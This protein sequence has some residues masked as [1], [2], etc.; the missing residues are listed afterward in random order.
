VAIHPTHEQEQALVRAFFGGEAA[1]YFVEVGAN[2]PTQGSQTW[3]LEQAGWTG[4]LVEPQPDLAAFLVSARKARVFAVACSSPDNAGKSMPLHVKGPHS[5]LD[6]E[7][8]SPGAEAA[9]A[10]VVPARTLD[11]ILDEAGAPSPIDLL[12]ID[13]EGHEVEV[14]QGFDFGRWQPLLILIE[15]HVAN[16]KT[17]RALK[18]NGYRLIRR[19]GHNGWYVPDGDEAAGSWGDRWE[20]LRKYYLALPF[21]KLRNAMR[22]VRGLYADWWAGR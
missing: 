21:R 6:R 8:M 2:H 7:R 10:I 1:G 14:L 13:V 9:Y 3:H 5:A 17:H 4:V 22:R 12:S 18:R 15:D 19:L 16:L 20:I 11:S